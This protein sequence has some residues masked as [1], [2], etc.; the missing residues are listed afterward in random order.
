MF[1]WDMKIYN[2]YRI[3]LPEEMLW[4]EWCR[5]VGF[6]IGVGC[7]WLKSALKTLNNKWA[8]NIFSF[9]IGKLNPNC[10]KRGPV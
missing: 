10:R 5:D 4:W 9:D 3:L 1:A 6:P 7:G 8:G 2:I